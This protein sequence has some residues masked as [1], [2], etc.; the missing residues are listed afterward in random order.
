ML[1]GLLNRLGKE[2]SILR[3][4]FLVLM[5]S[6]IFLH[7]ASSMIYPYEVLYLQALGASPSTIGLIGSLGTALLC[8]ST[9][10]GAYIADRYG[11]KKIIAIMTYGAALSNIFLAIAQDWRLATVGIALFNLCLIYRPALQ[12]I[13]AD[14]IPPESRG[15]GYAMVNVIPSVPAVLAPLIARFFVEEYGFLQGMRIVYWLVVFFCLIAA[16]VRALWLKETLRS[17]IKPGG[18]LGEFKRSVV[19]MITALKIMTRP[20]AALTLTLLISS[21]EEPMFRSFMSLYAVDVVGISKPDWALLSM[22]FSAVSLAVGIPMGKIVDIIGRKRALL[23]AY[24][25]WIPSTAYFIYCKSMIDMA[26]VFVAF[27]LGALLFGPAHQALLADLTPLKMRGRIMGIVGT[28]NLIVT[29]PASTL[30]GILYELNPTHPFMLCVAL[31]IVCV[32]LMI[33][34]VEEPTTRE[35]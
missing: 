4:N 21:F 11:R 24:A 30:G 34:F 15:L 26:L 2:F 20:L 12:A 19:E 9:I 22:I 3:G 29:I 13:T 10:P 6:W 35:V 5:I 32:I 8:I 7:F 23:M 17:S 16:T 14:S 25:L 18:L 1:C 27:A 31:G 33:L 28:L